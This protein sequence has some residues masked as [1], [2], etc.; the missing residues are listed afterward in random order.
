M[1]LLSGKLVNTSDLK[2]LGTHFHPL[3]TE[4]PRLSRAPS[5]SH[6]KS[7]FIHSKLKMLGL[8]HLLQLFPSFQLPFVAPPNPVC[9]TSERSR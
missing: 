8:N 5:P 7:T 4:F 3:F 2:Y 9:V 6:A 1:G